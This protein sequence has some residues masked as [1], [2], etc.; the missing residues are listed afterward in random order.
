MSV[1]HGMVDKGSRLSQGSLM[2]IVYDDVQY[3][4]NS[5]CHDSLEVDSRTVSPLTDE[6]VGDLFELFASVERRGTMLHLVVDV[7]VT[8][9]TNS[10]KMGQL[11][12]ETRLFTVS[13]LT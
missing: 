4:R 6:S 10:D 3:Q 2:L 9:R 1:A 11:S 5:D 12:P 8:G 13:T 7:P